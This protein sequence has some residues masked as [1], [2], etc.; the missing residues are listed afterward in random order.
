MVYAGEARGGGKVQ[1]ESSS[2]RFQCPKETL[3]ALPGSTVLKPSV[4]P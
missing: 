2:G 3:A 1:V 4:K